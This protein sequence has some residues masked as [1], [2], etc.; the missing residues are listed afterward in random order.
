MKFLFG[1][2]LWLAAGGHFLILAA[3][4]QVPG[5]LN[6]K[7]ELSNLM[8]FNR[9]LIWK[10]GALIVLTIIAFG[11]L[12]LYLHD[13]M[14]HG[15]P[16]SWGITIFIGCFWLCRVLTD[17][18]YFSHEDWPKG[19][20]LAVGHFLLTCLF[21]FLMITYLGLAIWVKLQ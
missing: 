3:S 1:I 10:G 11:A 15:N 6:W 9:K 8:P 20:L 16:V 13:E 2:A 12:T 21:C 14:L 5:K 7:S 4:F 17:F 19:P 18:F